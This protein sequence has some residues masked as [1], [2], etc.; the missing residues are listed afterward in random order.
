M[1]ILSQSRG[2]RPARTTGTTSSRA[3]RSRI[4]RRSRATP[5][6]CP[7]PTSARFRDAPAGV[8]PTGQAT[9]GARMHHTIRDAMT[10]SPTTIEPGTT[11]REAA[12]LMKS[13][14]VGSLPILENDRLVGVVTDRDLA[15]R[16]L[17]E[18]RDR[19]HEGRRDRLEGRRHRR[20]GAD[21]R[22]GRPPDGGASARGASRSARRTGSSS[23]CSRRRISRRAVTT[24]SPA[25]RC[26]RSRGRRS[27]W[28]PPRPSAAGPRSARSS[29]GLKEFAAASD[30][31]DDGRRRLQRYLLAG[32]GRAPALARGLRPSPRRGG[33]AGEARPRGRR[34]Q[35]HPARKPS[36]SSAPPRT[37]TR[38]APSRRPTRGGTTTSGGSI[39][40]SEPRARSSS[41]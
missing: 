17:A 32:A 3:R 36:A 5:R 24:R 39:G 27:S 19:R 20:S 25:R 22:G 16:L 7:A 9:E 28:S 38:G 30:R 8:P 41:G 37:T 34:A 1:R 6:T 4:P 26:S 10:A 15:I 40:W 14:D 35:A 11:A 31:E 33:R 13:E 23:G 29:I 12:R 2:S 18:G 21:A